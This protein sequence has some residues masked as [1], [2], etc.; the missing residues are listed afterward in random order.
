MKNDIL[1]DVLFRIQ[2]NIVAID[3]NFIITYANQAFADIISLKV[4][5]V[6]GKHIWT[7]MPKAVG[8]I[9]YKEIGEAMTKK[10]IRTFEWAGVYSDRFL[11]T[12]LFPSDN[13]LTIISRDITKRKQAE[14]VLRRQA[15]LIDLSPDAV[16]VRTLEGVITFWSNGAEKLYGYTKQEALGKGS[17][18]L[19]RTKFPISR[20]DVDAQI[21]NFGKWSGELVH[22]TK[23]GHRVIVQSRWRVERELENQEI[24]ILESNIDITERKRVEEALRE[25]KETL[26]D[27]L[28]AMDDGVTLAGLDGKVSDCNEASLKLLGLTREEFIGKNVY[29]VV[30]PEDRQR[31][32]EGSF[33][34]LETGRTLNEVRVLRKDGS[35]FYAEISVTALYDK[36]RK[37]IVFVGVTRDTTERKKV[38]MACKEAEERFRGLVESTSDMIWQV[39]QNAVYTYVSPKI[40]DILGYEPK[41]V[42]GKTPFDLVSEDD[43]E[44]IAKAFVEIANKMEP[45]YGLENWNVHKNGSLVLLETSGI[46]I[47]DEKGQLAGYRGIDRDITERKKAEEALRLSE[48][49]FSKVFRNSPNA[50][51]ITGLDDGAILEINES[52]VNLFGYSRE[53]VIGRTSIDLKVWTN[54]EDRILFTKTLSS[55]GYVRNHEYTL[56][57][58]DGTKFIV[59]IS[60]EIMEIQGQMCMVA[61][62]EDITSRK[63]MESKLEQ[64]SK[65]LEAIVEERTKQLQEQE[66]MAAIGATAGMVGHDLRNP[67]QTI[68]SE[69]YLAKSEL[70]DM[71]KGERK[72]TL[73][74]SLD[75]IAE[76]IGYMDKIVSDLQTFVKPVEPQ[77]QI[78]KLKTLIVALLTQT[79]FPK[80]IQVTVQIPDPLTVEADPQLLKRVLINLITNS[81]QAMPQGGDLTIMAKTDAESRVQITVEDTGV[82]IPEEVKP[83]VFTPLFTTKSKGQGFGLA[84]CKRVIEAQGGTISFESDVGKG[85]IF[86]VTLPA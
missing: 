4:S 32:I 28:N 86:I 17:N 36:N 30:V 26:Q 21:K 58:K 23:S 52:A 82:G 73:Q 34:V 85:T 41:E 25:S 2:D 55:Q 1:L 48:E 65:D 72:A 42:V 10:E 75:S 11:E 70:I 39:D 9:A 54:P 79:A 61:S 83:K 69:I 66:R 62:I 78:V 60:A 16:F 67:L 6:F 24:S 45:F 63:Q 74:E 56:R 22:T 84:V 71:P 3:N 19:L 14:D 13:G 27:I 51:T 44:E 46:P 8:T 5:E 38:E 68:V 80:N 29:D 64:Y 31:A 33:K 47:I 7:I 59:S 15:A 81:V 49:K 57:K 37:P 43:T 50:I 53:E 77:T 76:Q 20:G 40:K 35:V 18:V 12:I